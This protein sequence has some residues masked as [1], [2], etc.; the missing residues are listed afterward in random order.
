MKS[1]ANLAR[2]TYSD[3]PLRLA[4]LGICVALVL[5]ITACNTTTPLSP[6]GP[7]SVA[8]TP[9][10]ASP[11]S[12]VSPENG[13]TANNRQLAASVQALAV[14]DTN[15]P[16][17]SKSLCGFST[18]NPYVCCQNSPNAFGNCT[19]G[20]WQKAK[21]FGWGAGLP[22]RSWGNAG[23]SWLTGA[24]LD[25]YIVESTPSA[26]AIGVARMGTHVFFVTSVNGASLATAEQQCGYL[27]PGGFLY[28]SRNINYAADYIR[29]PIPTV[30]VMLW[31]GAA[32]STNGTLTVSRRAS[33]SFGF[34]LLRSNVNKGTSSYVWTVAGAVA[35]TAGT[36][37]K[38]FSTAGTFPVS[39]KVT[40]GLGVSTTVN[41]TVVV[42]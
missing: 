32:S 39:V 37:A 10:T 40:N 36:F 11:E 28:P 16:L 29:A 7:T 1:T 4:V 6:T 38:T 14:G 20:A 23:P 19:G 8:L 15:V 18:D 33:V 30:T 12:G 25:G 17:V 9:P 21:E 3:R 2:E 5:G 26:K 13:A 31:S 41:A 24:R 42:R 34:S 22:G 27:L 35:S